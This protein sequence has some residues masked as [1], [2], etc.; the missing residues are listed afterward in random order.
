MFYRVFFDPEVVRPAYQAGATGLSL[1]LSIWK[2]FL[3]NCS[4][5]EVDSY[6]VHRR[7]GEALREIGKDAEIANNGLS[8]YIACLKK[9]LGQLEKQN[10]F[11]DVLSTSEADQSLPLLALVTAETVGIDLILTD[12][13]LPDE[14]KMPERATF[15]S[16]AISNFERERS[17]QVDDGLILEGEDSGEEFFQNRFGRVLPLAKRVI[18]VDAILGRKFGD[19]F[20]YT[21]K[22][23]IDYLEVNH[24]SPADL[25][26]GIHTEESDRITLLEHRLGEW[27]KATQFKVY[28]YTE[29][30]HERYLFTDQFGLQLGIGM[31][32]LDRHSKRNRGTDFSYSRISKL[33]E[34]VPSA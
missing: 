5:C 18:I 24:S 20:Q 34:L 23:L 16:Y 21:L 25:V 17:K 3:L 15:S 9:I 6:L 8:D 27:C 12:E 29:V 22:R 4:I 28:R 7:L 30:T 1:L 13:K 33:S 2:N 10:R 26:L 14:P 19:N 31:D 11:V 32:L